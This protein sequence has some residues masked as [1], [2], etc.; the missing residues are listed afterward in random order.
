MVKRKFVTGGDFLMEGLEEEGDG[1]DQG[2]VDDMD[3]N[4]DEEQKE[5]K[6][7][8]KQQEEEEA[9]KKE[10]EKKTK[11]KSVRDQLKQSLLAVD[12]GVYKK[13]SYVKIELSGVKVKFFKKFSPKIPMIL[14]RVNPAEDNFGFLK[15]YVK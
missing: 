3:D 9:K 15:V 10:E 13:G 5:E 14:A 1:G 4:D 6:K 7:K 11:E 12:F 2:G 8:T